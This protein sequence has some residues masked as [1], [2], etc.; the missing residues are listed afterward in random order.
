MV[1]KVSYTIYFGNMCNYECKHNVLQLVNINVT[2]T[3]HVNNDV[4]TCVNRN[5]TTRIENTTGV[6]C[7]VTT[8]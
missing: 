5:A 2:V 4:T 7:N 1:M 3:I 6:N 8:K